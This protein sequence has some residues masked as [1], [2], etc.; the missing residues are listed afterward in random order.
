[1][2]ASDFGYIVPE[3]ASLVS[4]QT[5]EK[6]LSMIRVWLKV[7]GL[8][9]LRI[10]L[11]SSLAQPLPNTSWNAILTAEYAAQKVRDHEAGKR[12]QHRQKLRSEI[13][14]LFGNCVGGDSDIE[15][16]SSID[17]EQVN[18]SWLGIP[19]GQLEREHFEQILW[20]LHE[21]CFRYEFRALDLRARL[22]TP[23]EDDPNTES[24]LMQCFPDNSHGVPMLH[25]ANHGIA[26]LSS[27]ERAHYLFTMARVMSRWKGIPTRGLI[28]QTNKLRWSLDEVDAL[29]REIA[30]TYTQLF[31]N[32][33][34]RAAVV[35]HRLSDQAVGRNPLVGRSGEILLAPHVENNSTILINSQIEKWYVHWRRITRID[36]L[37][38]MYT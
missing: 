15:V 20:E 16:Q 3:P 38:R 28:A 34:R 32:C 27:R 37:L 8:C 7:H 4:T 22:H 36:F 26:S 24:L 17:L 12:A 21:L 30:E 5:K 6:S 11:K 31:F 35:P 25:A 2:R 23:F 1:M 10:S 33:F 19:Y 14:S 29:E 13:V 9:L 18:A